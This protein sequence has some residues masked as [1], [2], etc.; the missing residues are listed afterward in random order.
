M[1][2]AA[3]VVMT[4]SPMLCERH[5]E[6]LLLGLQD[7]VRLR[8]LC[9]ALADLAFELLVGLAQRLLRLLARADVAT[10]RHD[11]APPSV[12]TTVALISI[13]MMRPAAST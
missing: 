4:A 7:V 1:R 13:G 6:E 2:A 12:V 11:P 10:Q 9:R 5:A 3:S 8:E